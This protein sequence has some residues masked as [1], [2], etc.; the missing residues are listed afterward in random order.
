MAAQCVQGLATLLLLGIAVSGNAATIYVIDQ[1]EIG[2]HSA[3]ERSAPVLTLIPSGS[4]L[5][6]LAREGNFVRVRTD[7][8]AEGW[9]D[10]RYTSDTA[11]T[12]TRQL[13]LESVNEALNA[14]LTALRG[15]VER[16]K[17]DLLDSEENRKRQIR[18]IS[19]E[20]DS[21]TESLRKE[22]EALRVVRAGA[23]NLAGDSADPGAAEAQSS[24]VSVKLLNA[25]IER[26]NI[27]LSRARSEQSE[28]DNS[29]IPSDTLREMERLAEESR[30]AKE[31]LAQAESRAR[32]LAAV[33]G[34]VV[35][36]ESAPPAQQFGAWHW[37]LFGSAL[38]L[39]FGLGNLWSDYRVRQR[40]GGF[41]L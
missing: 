22:L 7:D 32:R 17:N 34:Q 15:E 27:E 36:A 39:M 3:A 38:L 6:E 18:A 10:A 37:A 26:L 8:G 19:R 23:T 13:E 12:A 25:E 1:F 14:E 21:N 5:E 31:K 40:H 28:T 2:L 33:A 16:L 20:A 30:N 4:S 41:R 24:N 9:V 11:S 29:R 35:S